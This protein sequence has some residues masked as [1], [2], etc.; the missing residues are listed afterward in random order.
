MRKSQMLYVRIKQ[1]SKISKEMRKTDMK[2]EGLRKILSF[3]WNIFFAFLVLGM[4]FGVVWFF[5]LIIE[6]Q[7]YQ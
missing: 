2:P 7:K 1:L 5:Y 3:A 4:V 6:I